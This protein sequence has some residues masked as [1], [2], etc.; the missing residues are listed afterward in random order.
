MMRVLGKIEKIEMVEINQD[1]INKIVR[2]EVMRLFDIPTGWFIEN[3]ILWKQSIIKLG[4]NTE[5]NKELVRPLTERDKAAILLL[6]KLN[7]D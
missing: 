6:A 7:K 3:N 5:K 4:L 1:A 2:Y